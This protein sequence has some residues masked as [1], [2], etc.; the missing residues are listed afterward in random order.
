VL[1]VDARHADS[2][3][4]LLL[5]VGRRIR[6]LRSILLRTTSHL[7]LSILH[8]VCRWQLQTF[9]LNRELWQSTTSLIFLL[10]LL[11]SRLC[12]NGLKIHL[13]MLLHLLCGLSDGQELLDAHLLTTWRRWHGY[14]TRAAYSYCSLDLG[15]W[16][17]PSQ[18]H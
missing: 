11:R 6:G 12:P 14:H 7:L 16:G 1:I 15:L 8:G 9:V 2:E 5:L 4:S 13:L 10:C 3:R 18:M 17:I